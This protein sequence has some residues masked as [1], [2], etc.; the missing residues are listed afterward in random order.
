M[1]IIV[2]NEQEHKLILSMID[3]CLR[4]GGGR[5]LDEAFK[6]K[7]SIVRNYTRPKVS[8]EAADGGLPGTRGN[9]G[10]SGKSGKRRQKVR[11]C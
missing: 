11:K 5:N 2:N 4:A 3:V 8:K 7:Q 10:E 1:K 9:K 6:V